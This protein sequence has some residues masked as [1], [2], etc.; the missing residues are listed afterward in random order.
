TTPSPPHTT[1]LLPYTT[2]FR[3]CSFRRTNYQTWVSCK[4]LRGPSFGGPTPDQFQRRQNK[5]CLGRGQKDCANDVTP[6]VRPQ[7]NSR[8]TDE[9]GENPVKPAAPVKQSQTNSRDG[10]VG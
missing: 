10:V 6:P 2:L 5:K 8:I 7:I 1:T 3:S 4:T 9:R